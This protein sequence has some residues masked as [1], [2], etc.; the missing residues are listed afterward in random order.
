MPLVNSCY[1]QGAVPTVVTSTSVPGSQRGLHTH[2]HKFLLPNSLQNVPAQQ[3]SKHKHEDRGLVPT[4]MHTKHA[5]SAAV[6]HISLA[7][8]TKQ[9]VLVPH[10]MHVVNPLPTCHMAGMC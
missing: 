6:V 9:L 5:L 7:E 10:D 2:T 4:R 1:K 3:P 8:K